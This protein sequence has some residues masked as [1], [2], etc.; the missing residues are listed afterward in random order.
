MSRPLLLLDDGLAPGGRAPEWLRDVAPLDAVVRPVTA[1]RPTA[2]ELDELAPDAARCSG[3][4][5]VGGGSTLDLGKLLATTR[6]PRVADRLRRDD[7][8]GLIP[9]GGEGGVRPPL[10]A[11]PTTLGTGSEASGTAC[12][13]SEDRRRLV[14]GPALRPDEVLRHDAA[15]A[16]LPDELER[17]GAVEA[18]LRAVGP[19]V[20]SGGAGEQRD[21]RALDDALVLAGIA[22]RAATG[23]LRTADRLRL[24]ELSAATHAPEYHAG[25]DPFSHR[26]WYLA[27]EL[28]SVTGL[29]KIPATALVLP[30]I[31]ARA[32]AGDERWGRADA[33]RR[34]WSRIAPE[35]ADADP[36]TGLPEL[37]RTWRV[38][39]AVPAGVDLDALALRTLRAWGGGLPTLA[40]LR[41]QD[42]RAVLRDALGEGPA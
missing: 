5:A 12:L 24:A 10:T 30:A 8:A 36:A 32:L 21:A 14:F 38:L 7:R 41:R 42:V 1:G 15:T 35:G 25:R 9:L 11:V 22:G 17:R 18:L 29:A 27:N 2:P 20:G 31:W 4:W 40:G 3:I 28:S 37:L 16:G 33:V 39:P 34:A 6:D 19:Y 23:R 26:A 13:T